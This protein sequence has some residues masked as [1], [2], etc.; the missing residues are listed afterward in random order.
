MRSRLKKVDV[1]RQLPWQEQINKNPQQLL[2]RTGRL[3]PTPVRGSP[4]P[5]ERALTGYVNSPAGPALQEVLE[6]EAKAE[7]TGEAKKDTEVE[8]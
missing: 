7:A 4:P 2:K 6:A 5:M 8:A 1:T 3:A